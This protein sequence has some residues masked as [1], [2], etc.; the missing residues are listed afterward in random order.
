MSD[1]FAEK[2][3]SEATASAS[4]FSRELRSFITGDITYADLLSQTDQCL[5]AGASAEQLLTILR[6][7][8]IVGK[9]PRDVRAALDDRIVHWRMDRATFRLADAPTIVLSE[10]AVPGDG[11]HNTELARTVPVPVAGDTL[12]GRFKLV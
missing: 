7:S 2:S 12:K 8:E 10:D 9:L 5:A 3:Q 6:D 4:G 1:D 11:A